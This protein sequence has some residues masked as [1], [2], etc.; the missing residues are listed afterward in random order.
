[1]ANNTYEWQRLTELQLHDTHHNG[2]TSGVPNKNAR[3]ASIRQTYLYC[4]YKLELL[5]SAER[6]NLQLFLTRMS[7][8]INFIH[9]A[10]DKYN[11]T[12]TGK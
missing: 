3:I 1:M 6:F 5:W 9:Q 10:V 12:N 11:E 7:E 2:S 4:K 8:L